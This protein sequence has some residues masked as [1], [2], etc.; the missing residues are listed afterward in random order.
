VFDVDMVE[1]VVD[2]VYGEGERGGG[3]GGWWFVWWVGGG[4]GGGGHC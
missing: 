1:L 2:G 3:V 4:G